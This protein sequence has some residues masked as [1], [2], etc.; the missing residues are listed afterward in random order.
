MTNDFEHEARLYY[1][2]K[3][4]LGM[5]ASEKLSLNR[6]FEVD[7][8]VFVSSYCCFLTLEKPTISS[9]FTIGN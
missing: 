4:F 9:A 1:K 7:R 2:A 6:G 8:D 3:I 5:E